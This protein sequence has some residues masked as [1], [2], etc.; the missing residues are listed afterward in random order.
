MPACAV[1]AQIIDRLVVDKKAEAPLPVFV[2]VS[3][4]WSLRLVNICR[5]K[6]HAPKT[7]THLP[8]CTHKH[9][10]ADAC[11]HVRAHTR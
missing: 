4:S 10:R 9:Q 5:E 1:Y 3:V 6:L 2:H 11:T 7:F 8:T